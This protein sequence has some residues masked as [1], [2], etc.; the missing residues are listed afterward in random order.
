VA[1]LPY[2][3]VLAGIAAGLFVTWQGSQ[4]AGPG[5]ALV[6]GVLLAAAVARLVLPPRFAGLLA[7]RS[8]ALDVATLAA[9]GAA[10][11]AVAAWLP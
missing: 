8:R 2:L 10:V 9:L 5:T 3:I 6:G 11:L 4:D 1:V 7:S